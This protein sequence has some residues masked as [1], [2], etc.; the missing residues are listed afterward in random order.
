MVRPRKV[1]PVSESGINELGSGGVA[2]AERAVDPTVGGIPSQAPPGPGQAPAP[3][4][5]G[6]NVLAQGPGMERVDSAVAALQNFRPSSQPLTA[7][8]DQPDV[9]LTAGMDIGP[10]PGARAPSIQKPHLIDLLAAGTGSVHLKKLARKRQMR[11][12]KAPG[13]AAQGLL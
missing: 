1:R 11:G 2:A 8:D 12:P 9:P 3:V 5:G 10:G 6:G 4:L 13:G 7:D